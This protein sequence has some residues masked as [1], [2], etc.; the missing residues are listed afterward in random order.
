MNLRLGEDG[1]VPGI[2]LLE[3]RV[4]GAE[5]WSAAQVR[6]EFRAPTHTVA[7]AEE[8]GVVVGYGFLS[9]AGD[10]ADLL[11]IAVSPDARRTGIASSLLQALIDAVRAAD[12]MLLEVASSNTGAHAF[13]AARGFAEIA[14]RRG[15]Y[16]SG[17][18]ALILSTPLR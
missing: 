7:V 18:D 2:V 9:E 11:R 3:S 5:A 12:R 6:E 8:D 10:V 15:Y 14:R 1:D 17:D 16:A 13:Y 4:F